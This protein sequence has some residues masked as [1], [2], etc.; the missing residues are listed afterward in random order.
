[1]PQVGRLQR[2]PHPVHIVRLRLHFAAL[3]PLDGIGAHTK[4]LGK[5]PA[6]HF[7]RFA[8]FS[9]IQIRTFR[10][11]ESLAFVVRSLQKED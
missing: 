9:K 3:P 5:L 10:H 11:A 2:F 6:R 1:M 7:S 8:R 4:L